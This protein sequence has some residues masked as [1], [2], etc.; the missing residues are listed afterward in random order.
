MH[1]PRPG[2]CP[3]LEV[4]TAGCFSKLRATKRKGEP[5]ASLLWLRGGKSILGL[6]VKKAGHSVCGASANLLHPS[7]LLSVRSRT[8][9]SWLL[10]CSEAAPASPPCLHRWAGREEF[11]LI[12]RPVAGEAWPFMDPLPRCT[13]ASV[14]TAT[15]TKPL[16]HA[17]FRTARLK[18]ELYALEQSGNWNGSPLSPRSSRSQCPGEDARTG[19]SSPERG[20]KTEGMEPG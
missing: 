13:R 20:Q 17:C 18:T 11:P 5:A 1:P 7:T 4:P 14:W 19:I 16:G 8:Y 9:L 10:P 15:R 3:P 12:C 6:E 2:R